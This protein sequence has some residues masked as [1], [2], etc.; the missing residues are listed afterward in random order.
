MTGDADRVL[1]VEVGGGPELPIVDGDGLARAVIWPGMGAELRSMHRI[2]LPPGGRTV[3]MKH[4]GEAA[5]YVIE[6]GGEVNDL[7]TGVSEP[8][9]EGSMVHVEPETSYL[10]AAG[11]SGLELVGGP[12]PAD[13][14][15]YRALGG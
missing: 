2:S 13:P 10:L 9:V 12:A 11:E 5:Y 14:A 1:V 15:L 4:P 7:G 8:L 6:G 3:A